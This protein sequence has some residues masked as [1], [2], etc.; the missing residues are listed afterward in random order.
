MAELQTISTE[1][2][3]EYYTGNPPWEKRIIVAIEYG[4]ISKHMLAKFGSKIVG[5]SDTQVRVAVYQ[6]NEMHW[7]LLESNFLT[8]K[9][10]EEISLHKESW[11]N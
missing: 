10:M 1:K 2:D 3:Y 8:P 9:Q 6:H 4:D 5:Y 7:G 11:E